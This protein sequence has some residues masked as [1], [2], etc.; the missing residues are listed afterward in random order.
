ML[1]PFNRAMQLLRK[2][3]TPESVLLRH[4]VHPLPV[5]QS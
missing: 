2:N 1:F 5:S 3:H 4:I